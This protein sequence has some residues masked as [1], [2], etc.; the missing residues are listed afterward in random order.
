[1]NELDRVGELVRAESGIVIARQ[2]MPALSA[3]L[4]RIEPGMTA[5]SFLSAIERPLE[6]HRLMSA[7]IDQFTIKETYLFREP[8]EL[9]AIDWVGALRSAREH[10]AEGV[11]V[12]VSACATGEEAYTIAILASEALGPARG[13]V[14]ILATDLSRAALEYAQVARYSPRSARNIPAHLRERYFQ[15]ER[16]RLRVREPI[17]SVVRFRSH[18][19]VTDPVPPVGE[20]AFDV[21][22]CR[23]VLIYFDLE[24]V[25]QVI[26]RLEGGLRP[27]GSLILG[28]ADRVTGTAS[29]L[30]G[31]G[32]VV[33]RR[34]PVR[35]QRAPART[36]TPARPRGVRTPRAPSRDAPAKAARRRIDE[37]VEDAVEAANSGDLDR[38]LQIATMVIEAH[39][40]DPDAHY[41]R[42]LA[43]RG[44]GDLEVA[45]AA[46]RR[47]LYV[48]PSFGLAAFE[49]GRTYDAL[50]D[51]SAARRAYEQAVRTL[52]PEDGRHQ[53]ILDY[54]EVA[55]VAAT[56]R[57]RLRALTAPSQGAL[58]S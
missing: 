13:S 49:L 21:I 23:N 40:L 52:D 4:A 18:N 43:A 33:D 48:D 29:R 56:C 31:H 41:I 39:P 7:L 55:D 20:V 50:A 37:R 42:G 8:R 44:T 57:S 28:A 27:H 47:A 3:A 38:A 54:V 10:G 53:A 16:D 6:R 45:V 19:L 17:R 25:S 32:V 34:A 12:W 30:T 26:D 22:S 36:R 58:G 2:Q 14:S 51:R 35:P 15:P 9:E 46:F 1:V 11:R 24:T 5:E